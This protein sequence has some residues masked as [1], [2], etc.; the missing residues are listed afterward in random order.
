M[1]RKKEIKERTIKY[2]KNNLKE[3]ILIVLIFFIGFFAGIIAINNGKEENLN[4]MS[5]YV[6][7][8]IEKFKKIEDINEEEIALESIKNNLMLTFKIW[9]A[10]TTIIGLPVVLGFVA[11]RGFCLGYTV[12]CIYYTLGIQKTLIFCLSNL[13]LQNIIFIPAILTLGVSSYKLCKA[14]INDRR[15]ENIKLEIAKH[16][17]VSF[18]ISILLIASSI[19]ENEVSIRL[20]KLVIQFL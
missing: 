5:S 8:F 11:F 7:D 9:L 18:F 12:S 4:K 14:I 17:L 19:I 15:K 3:Y 10:G 16:T 1:I 20:L 2:I 6:M 13:F